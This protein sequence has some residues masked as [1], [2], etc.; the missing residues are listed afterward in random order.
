MSSDST[1]KEREVVCADVLPWLSSR[2]SL[3]G[4]SIVASMPDYSEFPGLSLDE[5]K[6]WFTETAKLIL[7]RT[8]DDGAALFFQSDIKRDGVW[9]DKGY[10]VAKAAEETGHALLFHKVLCRA[11]AGQTT[12]GKPSYSHLLAFSRGVRPPVDESTA[13]VIPDLG[14]KTW[15]RGMGV[16]ACRVACE[17]ILRS[18]KTRTV[19]SLFAGEGSVVA[20]AN[21]IGLHAIGVERSPKRAERARL[22]RVSPSGEGWL[23]LPETLKNYIPRI[24]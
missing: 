14:E 2:E 4:C 15:A 1:S 21:H 11:P 13:D 22:L 16:V 24:D 19:V 10:L 5:W 7:S 12:F 9:I 23:P 18:T 20:Y 17:F 8:P 6:T 3:P